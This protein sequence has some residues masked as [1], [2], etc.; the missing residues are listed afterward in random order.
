MDSRRLARRPVI[1]IFSINPPEKG[2]ARN[3]RF[4]FIIAAILASA[5]A[6]ANPTSYPTGTTIYAWVPDG[7]PRSE[8]GVKKVDVSAFRVP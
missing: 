7:T 5:A 6:V 8:K 3:M 4:L 1:L 2:T